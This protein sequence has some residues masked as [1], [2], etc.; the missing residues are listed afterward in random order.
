[1]TVTDFAKKAGFKT[2]TLP[3][4]DKEICGVY[5]GDLLSWVMG[6]AESG[7]LWIT[8]MSNINILAV[9]TLTD[10]S[11]ILLAENV[12]PDEE[13]IKRAKEKGVNVLSTHLSAYDAAIKTA[14]I[15]G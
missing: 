4:P 3:N 5:V 13:L 10:S 6:K 15:I 1:M 8:I 2:I 14:E 11:C 9:A 7:N 12:V